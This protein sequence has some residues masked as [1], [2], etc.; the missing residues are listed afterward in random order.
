M[1]WKWNKVGEDKNVIWGDKTEHEHV[2]H[3]KFAVL[4][5]FDSEAE[6]EAAKAALEEA[7]D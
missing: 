3:G 7:T 5:V 4:V 2:P 6:A 1:G